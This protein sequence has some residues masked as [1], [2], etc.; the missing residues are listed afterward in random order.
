MAV[1][2]SS[3]TEFFLYY[4]SMTCLVK[5]LEGDYTTVDFRDESC[6]SGKIVHVDGFMNIEME[7]CYYYNSRGRKY[8]FE[9]FFV[10]ARN[11]R[12]IHIPQDKD[13]LTI[14]EN[15]LSTFRQPKQAVRKKLTYK[16]KRAKNYQKE[17]LLN[18]SK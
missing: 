13:V 18:L 8:P 6:V 14:I 1:K 4:N 7:N 9:S 11:V 16:E 3:A 5:G 17:L 12:Y 2:R 10:K 15:Q